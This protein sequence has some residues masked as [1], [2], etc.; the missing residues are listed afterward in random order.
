MYC[1]LSGRRDD[2]CALS[3]TQVGSQPRGGIAIGL[4]SISIRERVLQVIQIEPEQGH[5]TVRVVFHEAGVNLSGILLI[6]KATLEEERLD[7]VRH[8]LRPLGRAQDNLQTHQSHAA[9]NVH[10]LQA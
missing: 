1:R 8:A 4:S 2:A 10:S 5:V 7:Q 9:D 6:R 3:L